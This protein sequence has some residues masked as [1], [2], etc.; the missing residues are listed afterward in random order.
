MLF[1]SHEQLPSLND[2]RVSAWELDL[3]K[4]IDHLQNW[5][6]HSTVEASDPVPVHTAQE[7]SDMIVRVEK[8]LQ[9]FNP[10]AEELAQQLTHA[11]PS[12]QSIWSEINQKAHDFDFEGALA[13]LRKHRSM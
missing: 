3:K 9:D 11:D 13:A 7:V 10:E 4:V 2:D 6:D 8:L 1:R 12:N 5:R